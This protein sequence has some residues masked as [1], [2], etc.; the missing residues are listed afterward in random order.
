MLT[1]K[2]AVVAFAATIT[3]AGTVALELLEL[4]VTVAPD[5]PDGPLSVMVP[6]DELPPTTEVG[7]RLRPVRVAGLIVRVP[8]FEVPFR[9]PVIVEVVT[10]ETAVVETV[11]VTVAAPAGTTTVLGTVA[12][13]VEDERGTVRPPV[14]ALPL[15]VMVPVDD[16]PPFTVVGERVTE[17]R[18]AGVIVKIV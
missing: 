3:V 8:V 18:T 1:V 13:V 9:V 12:L 17:L 10:A 11:K 16:V 2:V 6:V 15:S 7:E 14:G 4:K 5:G